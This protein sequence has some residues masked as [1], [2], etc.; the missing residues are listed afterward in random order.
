MG[1]GAGTNDK[2]DIFI[3]DLQSGEEKMIFDHHYTPVSFLGEND[4]LFLYTPDNPD[5][6]ESK[7][8]L[9]NVSQNK[10]TETISLSTEVLKNTATSFPYL[11][12]KNE[13]KI[14]I[15]NA[16]DPKNQNISLDIPGVSR[17]YTVHSNKDNTKSIVSYN[18]L[19]NPTTTK[20]FTM[21][22]WETM[23]Y[24][25]LYFDHYAKGLLLKSCYFTNDG[26]IG[27]NISDGANNYNYYTT[28]DSLKERTSEK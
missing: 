17:V 19:G 15:K 25:H 22:D 5:Q 12:S 10:T 28:V 3:K 9:Y 18:L 6:M 26:N 27:V 21:I 4:I 13:K 16:A 14:N 24:K 7:F 8:V 11:I 2:K 23:E 20:F 1:I